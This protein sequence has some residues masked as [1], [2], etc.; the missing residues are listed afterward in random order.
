MNTMAPL[1]RWPR[2]YPRRHGPDGAAAQTRTP[3]SAS[4]KREDVSG[5]SSNPPAAVALAT[6]LRAVDAN[7][8]VM[9]FGQFLRRD[10]K[11]QLCRFPRRAKCTLAKL[12]LVHLRAGGAVRLPLRARSST[13]DVSTRARQTGSIR[14]R[15]AKRHARR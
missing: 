1:A 9:A 7:G 3:P 2:A 4:S 10:D 14:L 15:C 13:D 12:I 11:H 8:A 6:A 5:R